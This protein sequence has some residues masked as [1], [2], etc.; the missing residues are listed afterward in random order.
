MDEGTHGAVSRAALAG[1]QLSLQQSPSLIGTG[2]DF[3]GVSPVQSKRRD[4]LS[5]VPSEICRITTT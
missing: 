5:P 4:W 1:T 2:H 3:T